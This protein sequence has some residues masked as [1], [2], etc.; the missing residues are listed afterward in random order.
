MP[1]PPTGPRTAVVIPFSFVH[2]GEP[3]VVRRRPG[4]PRRL[5][6][7]PL[8]DEA[9]YNDAVAAEAERAIQEDATV[10]TSSGAP[11][12][13]RMIQ[14]ALEGAAHESAALGFERRRAI[15]EGRSDAEKISSRRV[16]AL[17]RVAELVVAREHLRRDSSE[18][19]PQQVG[20]AVQMLVASVESVITEVADPAIAD[21]FL[22]RL[23]QK[24]SAANFPEAALGAP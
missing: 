21:L 4:R 15:R 13:A 19:D 24:L 11:E 18:L 8:V 6:R 12:P 3:P 5:E 1:K 20:Q 16:Q 9:L 22:S 7:A 10:L 2:A 23:Q 14:R 17:L